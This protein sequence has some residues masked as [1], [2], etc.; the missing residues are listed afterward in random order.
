MLQFAQTFQDS[1]PDPPKHGTILLSLIITYYNYLSSIMSNRLEKVNSL[2]QKEIGKIILRDFDF[3]GRIVTLTHVNTTP[4]L[5]ETRVY[6]SVF[7]DTTV[8]QVIKTLNS[9]V[10]VIQQQVNKKLNMRPIPRIIFIKD[11]EIK[12]ASRVEEILETLKKQEK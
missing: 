8:N 10:V 2:L 7:P 9:A 6:I 3:S 5:I 1:L 11:D 4:N 12:Q